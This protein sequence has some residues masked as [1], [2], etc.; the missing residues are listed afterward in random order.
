MFISAKG[1]LF[2]P[3]LWVVLNLNDED[4]KLGM[5]SGASA[6]FSFPT[7]L[8][9]AC[10]CFLM[11]NGSIRLAQSSVHL[12]IINPTALSISGLT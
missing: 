3:F 9:S 10:L 12:D 8:S 5:L 4:L 6:Q 11:L 7:F 1:N 2:N